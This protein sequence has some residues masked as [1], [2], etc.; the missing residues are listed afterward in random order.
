MRSLPTH[1][2]TGISDSS[3]PRGVR[4]SFSS[5]AWTCMSLFMAPS[6]AAT[7]GGVIMFSRDSFSEDLM[8]AFTL[9]QSI[10]RGTRRISGDWNFAMCSNFPDENRCQQTPGATLPALPI[11]C[12]A[13]ALLMKVSLSMAIPFSVSYI[14]SLTLPASMM[15]VTSSTVMD[16]SAMF[17]ERMTFVVPFG[18]CL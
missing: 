11:L 6:T 17:V 10:S 16:V 13:D 9:R 7:S 4:S 1:A 8:Q 5:M 18:A 15:N 14:S 2:S 3:R 12:F